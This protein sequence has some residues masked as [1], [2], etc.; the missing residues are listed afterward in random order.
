M[1]PKDLINKLIKE[2][3]K[4]FI[5]NKAFVK[6]CLLAFSSGLHIIIDDISG[7][8]KTTLVKSLAKASV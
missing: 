4:G 5:A 1:N 6:D 7:I 3:S 2:T 8:G